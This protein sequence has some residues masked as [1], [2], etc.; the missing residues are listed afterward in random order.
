M[1]AHGN[2]FFGSSVFLKLL[3]YRSSHHQ[4]CFE[5]FLPRHLDIFSLPFADNF[6]IVYLGTPTLSTVFLVLL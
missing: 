3:A 6:E 4:V 5:P 2:R 1:A